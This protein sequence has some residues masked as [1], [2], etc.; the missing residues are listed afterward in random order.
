MGLGFF[1]RQ[2][3]GFEDFVLHFRGNL[4]VVP[5][6][7]RC[8]VDPALITITPLASHPELSYM[9]PLVSALTLLQ[10]LPFSF[11]CS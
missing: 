8:Y 7:G 11:S 6:T 5:W 1:G 9:C 2:M 4:L 10:P 3:A